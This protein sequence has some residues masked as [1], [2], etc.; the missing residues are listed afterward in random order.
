M[1][2]VIVGLVSA[3]AGF[4][5]GLLVPWIK[6]QIEKRKE[7]LA[8]RRELIKSWR[9]AISSQVC[10]VGDEQNTFLG[11]AEYSSLRVHLGS[12]SLKKVEAMRTLYVNGARG[13]FYRNQV[14]LDEVARLEKKWGLV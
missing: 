11:S 14:L 9:S 3:T 12:E 1:S 2:E 8:Y 10:D 5:S 13:G 4:I 6:W 7:Q